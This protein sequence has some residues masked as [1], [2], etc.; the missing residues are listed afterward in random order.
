MENLT[1]EDLTQ[2]SVN[3]TAQQNIQTEEKQASSNANTTNQISGF[4]IASLVLGIVSFI[5]GALVIGGVFGIL[6]IIFGIIALCKK[7]K[8]PLPIIGIV[9][10]VLG[11]IISIV[12]MMV[13]NIFFGAI[14]EVGTE[15]VDELSKIE[16]GVT[17]KDVISGKT[18][19]EDDGSL[20]VLNKDNTFK[21]YRDKD[22][23]TNYYYEGTYKVYCGEDAVEY[24]SED[25]EDYGVTEKEQRDI[26]DRNEEYNVDNYYCLVLNNKTCMIDGE[27]TM[28][29]PVMTPYFGFYLEKYDALDIANMNTGT[30]YWF[31]E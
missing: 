16:T 30:Y 28:E 17:P 10:S 6:S 4:A 31:T 12:C 8:S 18:W 7:E 25:L 3:V 29:E 15:L 2:N 14:D 26:F 21:Y 19:E 23:L 22:D 5:T 9:L 13:Y 27:N 11:I 24:I 20:L 1:G